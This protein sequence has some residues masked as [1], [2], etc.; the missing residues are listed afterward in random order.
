[1]I[2]RPEKVKSTLRITCTEEAVYAVI[3]YFAFFS[4]L[5]NVNCFYVTIV[6]RSLEIQ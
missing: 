3:L 5:V 2:D 1:M 6:I 4:C